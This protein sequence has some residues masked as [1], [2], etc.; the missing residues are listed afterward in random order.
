MFIRTP[1]GTS[2]VEPKVC[3]S[4]PASRPCRP[5]WSRSGCEAGDRGREAPTTCACFV[6]VKDPF[7]GRTSP[8]S[9]S[10]QPTSS[11][12]GVVRP[13]APM[14]VVQY[15]ERV[16]ATKPRWIDEG[17]VMSNARHRHEALLVQ[18][19]REMKEGRGSGDRANAIGDEMNDLWAKLDNEERELFDELSED[20]YLIEGKRRVVPLDEGETI[21]SVREQ[22]ALALDERRD[23]DALALGPEARRHRSTAHL[24]HRQVLGDSASSWGQVLPRFC[25]EAPVQARGPRR[26]SRT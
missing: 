4:R 12:H 21:A 18:L 3:P 7:S 24:R 6:W 14:P 1:R 11:T 16:A 25:L 2:L 17:W 5:G 26:S 10:Y 20:L 22:L 15:Q 13:R 23:R 9:W 8:K 19:H